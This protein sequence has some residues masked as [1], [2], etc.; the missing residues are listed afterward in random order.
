MRLLQRVSPRPQSR[1]RGPSTSRRPAERVEVARAGEHHGRA[2]PSTRALDEAAPRPPGRPRDRPGT[3][4]T[5]RR[6]RGRRARSPWRRRARCGCRRSRC[7]SSP[8]PA[9]RQHGR[10]RRDAPVGELARRA[11]GRASSAR[12][13]STLTHDVPPAPE[14]SMVRDARRRAAAAATA[15]EMPQPVSFADDRHRQLAHEPREGGEAAAEVAVAAR[16]DQLLRRVEMEAE[17]VGADALRPARDLGGRR[18]RPP[19]RRPRFAST[20]VVGACARTA[21]V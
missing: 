12:S 5:P 15:R 2:Q 7:T 1:S 16:L 21:K 8:R 10:G 17:R 19:A 6:P 11:P 13:A 3:P 4:A 20:S 14:T 9:H 18:A